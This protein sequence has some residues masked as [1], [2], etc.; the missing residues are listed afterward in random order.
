MRRLPLPL[1]VLMILMTFPV[2][3][4]IGIVSWMWDRR[5]MRAVAE[6]T[7]CERC[8]TT[9]GV[10]ALQSAE[11]EW[12]KRVAALLDARPTMRFRMI[13]SLWAVCAVCGAE[14]SYDFHSR[15]F[16]CI[17]GSGE[18]GVPDQGPAS[19]RKQAHGRFRCIRARG[20]G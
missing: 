4:P 7:H 17:A 10:T 13:R 15:I 16:R 9:L 18:P 1:L 6:R 8:G 19:T 20:G 11:A 14:F 2:T 12:T 5:R 3:I